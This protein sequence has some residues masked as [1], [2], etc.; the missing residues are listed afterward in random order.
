MHDMRRLG[1]WGVLFCVG[2][3]SIGSSG[4]QEARLCVRCVQLYAAQGLI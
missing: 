3:C 2:L 4:T 1:A